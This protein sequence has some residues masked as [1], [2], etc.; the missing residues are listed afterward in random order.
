MLSNGNFSASRGASRALVAQAVDPQGLPA[1]GF[2]GT[3]AL[4]TVV[5]PGGDRAASFAPATTWSDAASGRLAIAIRSAD[6]A[7]LA[8]GRYRLLTRATAPE[9]DPVDIYACT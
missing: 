9:N 6:T 7:V 1:T 8:P 4:A 3:E 5:W 2:A